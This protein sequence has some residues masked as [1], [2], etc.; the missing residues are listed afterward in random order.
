MDYGQ[1]YRATNEPRDAPDGRRRS[2]GV[3]RYLIRSRKAA[4]LFRMRRTLIFTR[5]PRRSHFATRDILPFRDTLPGTHN[6]ARWPFGHDGNLTGLH[7][8]R[9]YLSMC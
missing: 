9:I 1:L 2:A 3:L 7:S 8:F 4:V 6:V 5:L